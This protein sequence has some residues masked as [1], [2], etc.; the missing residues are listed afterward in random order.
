MSNQQTVFAA[1]FRSRLCPR[2]IGSH[3]IDEDHSNRHARLL[4]T[5][6]N[7]LEL[8]YIYSGDGQYMVDGC[9]YHVKRG[10]IVICNA[11]ILHGED[12]SEQRQMCSYSIA[13][14]DIF[15][16]GLP[17]NHLSD[18]KSE[19]IVSC[20]LLAQQVGEMMQLIYLLHSKQGIWNRSAAIQQPRSCC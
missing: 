4:H 5:H 18:T 11:G 14:T 1:G 6:K 7:E 19:P 9:S 2:L 8:L 20:G 16:E 10:D 12:P 3:F 15:L 17:D 13:M